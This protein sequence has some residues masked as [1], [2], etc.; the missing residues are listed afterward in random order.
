LL[1]DRT[2][3]RLA[4][5]CSMRVEQQLNT[6]LIRLHGEF[7]L[8]CEEPFREELA[9]ALDEDTTSLVLDLRALTFM[10]SVG[11][12]TLVTINRATSDDGLDFTVLCGEGHVRRVLRETGLDGVLPVVDPS[13][14]VPASDSP[15]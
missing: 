12:R 10:D 7:D 2:A 13:G 3:K 15:V 1:D 14:T 11:L 4:Q 8:S 6:V 9:R 5:L